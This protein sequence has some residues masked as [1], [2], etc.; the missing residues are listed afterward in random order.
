MVGFGPDFSLVDI[1]PRNIGLVVTEHAKGVTA[2]NMVDIAERFQ[3][4]IS[5]SND[6]TVRYDS[7]G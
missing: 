1:T 4:V 6:A 2:L 5:G 3:L 7:H